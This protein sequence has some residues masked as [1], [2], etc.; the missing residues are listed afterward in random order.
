LITQI[1]QGQLSSQ[2]PVHILFI[3]KNS[4]WIFCLNN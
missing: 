1:Q 2:H 3:G 4:I